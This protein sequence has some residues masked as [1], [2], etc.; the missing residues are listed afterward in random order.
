MAFLGS[1]GKLFGISTPEA[2]NIAAS[3]A[4]GGIGQAALTTLGSL[5]INPLRAQYSPLTCQ[6]LPL[7]SIALQRL[8]M[9]RKHLKH[10]EFLPMKDQVCL[11]AQDLYQTKPLLAA[12]VFLD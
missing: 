6:H 1:V 10:L 8:V 2:A 12:L 11:A 4:T 7:A 3:F 9:F 5:G